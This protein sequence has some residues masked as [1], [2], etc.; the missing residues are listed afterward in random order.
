MKENLARKIIRD[1]LVNGNMAFG[2]EIC[3]KVDQTLTQD[4]TGTMTYLQLE[5]ME[6]ESV[7]TELSVAYIDHNM[8]QTG[9]E[10]ADDHEF[11]KSCALKYGIIFSKPGNGICHQLHLERFGAPG[12]TLIGSDSHTPTNGGMGALAIGAGG[13]DV[14]IGMAKGVYYFKMPMIYNIE[15]KGKLSKA[16][17]AKDVILY[18]L[19]NLTVKGGTNCIIEYSGDGVKELS[20]TERATITNMGAELGATSSIFPSDENT[21]EF[22]KRQGREKDYVKLSADEGAEYDKKFVVELDKLEP[23]V[24]YPHSP[25]NVRSVSEDRIK[26]HQVA[27]G[28][29]TNS[30]YMDLMTAAKILQ[31]KTVHKDVDLVISPGSSNII[32][33][34]SNNGALSTFIKSGARI[35][36]AGCGPCIGMG[37]APR[38]KGKSLRTFNRNFKGRCGTLDAE[39]Y[40]S[41]P[42]V[43]A[44]S[45]I[46]GY[47]ADPREIDEDINVKLP[48][49]FDVYSSYFIY[50]LEDSEREKISLVKGP[51]IGSFPRNESLKDNIY[52]KILL[53]TGDNITTDDIVPS[54][55]NM[56]KYRSNIEKLS[57]FSF[58]TIVPDF[59]ERCVKYGG[60]I[61]IGKENY[62][63]GSSREHAALVPL[64]LGIKAIIAKSFAR[65]H[66]SN[67]INSGIL[68]LEF[69]NY[70][71]YFNLSE[72]EDIMLVNLLESIDKGEVLVK[73]E[74]FEFLT[75]ITLSDR[76]KEILKHGGYLN[77]AMK[78]F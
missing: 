75:N 76:E 58:N 36:E 34:L 14:A 30:S 17:G 43:A 4:T 73:T 62:G 32:E 33:M 54:N 11:I 21:L 35:L 38:S 74:N 29:C 44:Y 2:E 3:I 23:Y 7:K 49:K 15:L 27:I 16:V 78:T 19:K 9:F 51:N 70:E 67:L 39:V 72:F 65:I 25:D 41:G 12:K 59:K 60:G 8:L 55:A 18:I 63:Q 56:L 20:L 46:K 10:N 48:E 69:K 28:S 47:I 22:L 31:G 61:I 13:L 1:H 68:P 50:K 40:L 45:A 64:Y 37:Q 24:A 66:K 5:A 52:T 57:E 6:I 71:D 53:K 26:I 77:Y 42:M